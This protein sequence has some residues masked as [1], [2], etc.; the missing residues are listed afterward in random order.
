MPRSLE[1][2]LSPRLSPELPQDEV[3]I[4]APESEPSSPTS[5]LL[6]LLLPAG[7]TATV[8]IGIGIAMKMSNWIVFSVPMILASSL[9]TVI[10]YLVQKRY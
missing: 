1:F 7:L 5:S 2:S 10:S 9:A 6:S 3:E 4:P 8:M